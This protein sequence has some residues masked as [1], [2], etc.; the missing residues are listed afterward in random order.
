MNEHVFLLETA[1]VFGV[2]E[3][4]KRSRKTIGGSKPAFIYTVDARMDGRQPRASEVVRTTNPL[5]P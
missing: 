3:K 2:G 5:F 1:N 4:E